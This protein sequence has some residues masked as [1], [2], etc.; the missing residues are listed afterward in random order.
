MRKSKY[1][2]NPDSLSYD[3]VRTNLRTKLVRGLTYFFASGAI[4]VIYY[5]CYSFFFD[6]PVERGL[7]RENAL[8]SLQFE[9]LSGKF[10]QIEKVIVDLE[11]RDENIYRTI[12]VFFLS[13][14][15]ANN[16]F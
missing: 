14:N 2:F 5:I 7:K 9:M 15:G 10:D 8:L 16:F 11:Q 3:R 1:H 13:S 4:A 6:T 12:F